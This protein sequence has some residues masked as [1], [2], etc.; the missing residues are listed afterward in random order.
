[1]KND[2]LDDYR[3]TIYG[4]SMNT[5]KAFWPVGSGFGSFVDVYQMHEQPAAI[6]DAYVNAAHN[7][8]LQF[9]LEGGAAAVLL[10]A[11]F[12]VLLLV[13]LVR[14]VRFNLVADEHST[15]VRAALLSVLLLSAHAV[16][17]FGLRTPALLSFFAVTCGLACLSGLLDQRRWQRP[18][19]RQKNQ[20][21]ET[22]E[23]PMVV[24]RDPAKPFFKVTEPK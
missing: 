24:K 2:P 8:W 11:G 17:D 10:M 6:V 14:T 13:A 19:H 4:V 7:D 16:V 20:V 18:S 1:L 3:T 15:T 23:P 9:G 5:A 12:L 21:N 22:P